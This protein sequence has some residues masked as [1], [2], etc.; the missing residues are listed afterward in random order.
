MGRGVSFEEA[1]TYSVAGTSE[2][3]GKE[4]EAVSEP[5]HIG[6]VQQEPQQ[7][8]PIY[9]EQKRK[10]GV[11]DNHEIFWVEWNG[12]DD[13]QNP[14]N[15]PKKRKW[16]ATLTTCFVSILT[17]LPAGAYGAAY[18]Q[19]M[20]EWHINDD[21]FPFL[22][23]AL[24]SWNMG[25]AFFPLVF[26][27]LTE[28][29]GRLPGYWAFY[30]MFTLW[31]FGSAYAPNFATILITRFFGGGASSVAITLVAGTITDIW[32]GD[33]E[34]SLP[35]SIFGITSVVGIAL[36]PFVGGIIQNYLWWRWIYWIQIIIC[37]G[38]IP[39]F[40]YI[41]R[42]TR[43]DV[44]LQKKAAKL[45]KEGS[46]S[47]DDNSPQK[48]AYAKSE[49][50]KPSI[51]QALKISFMRP[52]KM[53]ISEFVVI[54]FTIWVS[55][56]WGLLFLFQ[57]SV[58]IVFSKLYNF[59]T[60]QITLVQLAVSV[61]AIIGGAI[62]P[63]QD[64]LYFKSARRNTERPGKCIPEARLYFAVPGSVLFAA[65]MFWFGWSAYSGHAVHWIVPTLSLVT[66]GIGVYHIYLAVTNYLADAYEKYAASA[67]S[68]AGF[69]RNVTGA[70]LPLA[71]PALY[72]NLGFNWASTM[73]GILALVLTAAPIALLI[74]GPVIRA[75][76]PFMLDATFDEEESEERKQSMM[77]IQGEDFVNRRKSTIPR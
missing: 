41:L 3:S 18:E 39:L 1:R 15:W 54:S 9:Q 22:S 42:E 16:I 21:K 64:R 50:D 49:L 45:R 23:F 29:T 19:M 6:F 38:F 60:F 59:D 35:I 47:N 68:A 5:H 65:S 57:S 66:F 8:N 62:N 7:R 74:K 48:Y 30:I 70:F 55:F 27:P 12:P 20:A 75:N 33:I 26:V 17:G 73:L 2:W 53:L 44:I 14:F 63:I 10:L 69:G 13:P 52:T 56:A 76:S 31:L 43:G 40:A 61:G 34:R 32:K 4:K 51:V 67:L 24:V 28:S 71:T 36:G 58:G 11:P 46:M 37:T 77:S 72:N 25:A